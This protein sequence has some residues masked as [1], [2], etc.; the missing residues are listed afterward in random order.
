MKNGPVPAEERNDPFVPA[1][2]TAPFGTLLTPGE[3]A[4]DP[5]PFKAEYSAKKTFLRHSFALNSGAF[6]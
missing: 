5:F 3:E 2:E 6:L 4:E 1:G